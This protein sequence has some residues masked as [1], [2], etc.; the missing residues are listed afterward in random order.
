MR[1]YVE[2]PDEGEEDIHDYKVSMGPDGL[3]LGGSVAVV[4]GFRDDLCYTRKVVPMEPKKYYIEW[5]EG[6]SPVEEDIVSDRVP[7]KVNITGLSNE[8]VVK[9]L[10]VLNEAGFEVIIE[11]GPVGVPF[12]SP[13]PY[14]P[15]PPYP[16]RDPYK[17]PII[18]NVYSQG[19]PRGEVFHK[20][21]P[22]QMGIHHY[23]DED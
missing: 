5:D 19:T 8:D 12:P 20:E 1:A 21:V 16:Y 17:N 13:S 14:T 7:V 18:S 15:H 9:V 10:S 4:L 23:L 2:L 11:S 22:G 6:Q 3:E